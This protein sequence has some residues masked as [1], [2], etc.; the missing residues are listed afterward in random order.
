M[1]QAE[2][3]KQGI[4]RLVAVQNNT[5]ELAIVGTIGYW[6]DLDDVDADYFIDT[7][8]WC[9]L[10][11]M[12]V[13]VHIDSIGGSYIQGLRIAEAIKAYPYGMTT[14]INDCA[15]SM[16]SLI[17]LSGKRREIVSTA[18]GMMIHEVWAQDVSGTADQLQQVVDMLR[19][20]KV[21][22]AEDYQRLGGIDVLPL[23]DGKDHFFSPQECLDAG[24]VDEIVTP[25]NVVKAAGTLDEKPKRKSAELGQRLAA[26]LAAHKTVVSREP[27]G[28]V[29]AQAASAYGH[30]S[31]TP[32]AAAAPTPEKEPTMPE[33]NTPAAATE[34]TAAQHQEIAAKA[35]AL[36]TQRRADIGT[37]FAAFAGREGVA[38]LQA[39]CQADTACT[40]EAANKQLL[41]HLAVGA[42]PAA[43]GYVVAVEDE[44]DKRR[45][46]IVQAIMAR[47]GVPGIKADASN[48]WR[49]H[50][51]L[52]LARAALTRAGIKTDGMNQMEIVAAAFTSSTSDFPVL[53]EN[54]MHK[55]L[56]AAYAVAPD[57]WTRFCAV[58]S[59]SDFRAHPRYRRGSFGN[60]DAVN[61]NGEYKNKRISDGEK[62]S[63]TATTKGNIINLSRQMIINDDL[64]AFVAVAG[65][66]GR[67]AKRTVEADVYTLIALNSGLGPTMSDG[68]PLFHARTATGT[69]IGTGAALSM[70]AIDADR[71]IMASQKDISGNDY[72]DLRPAVLL[73]PLS[74]GGAARSINE[75]QYD[76]DT[77]N[78]LQKP[79]VVNGLFRDIVDTPRLTG[80]RRYLFADPMEAPVIEVAFLDGVQEPYL[81]MQNGFDVDGTQYKVRLDYGV[82][83]VGYQGAVTNAGA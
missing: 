2:L 8:N 78:K 58:G 41:A 23:L 50:K 5:A 6:D 60:L 11:G 57:T 21:A 7:L 16:A 65:D 67:A 54:A 62:Q 9:A 20:I 26:C 36:D 55:T 39:K 72:L 82:G 17:A 61:E 80:T 15:Y 40:V 73:V 27:A 34:V 18:S 1:P 66:F 47:A 29:A 59:V 3:K 14:R 52:D 22:F 45:A 70:A 74:L 53:L 81:E 25:D 19:E 46:G 83:A 31:F 33:A 71:V 79:N 30:P 56:Q 10:Q 28:P 69:N 37:A 38:D 44:T 76:P 43:G 4:T 24:Y 77:A 35:L 68:N 32:A 63:I 51:L 49:G 12:D 13:L 64:G 75:A 42:A 48:P